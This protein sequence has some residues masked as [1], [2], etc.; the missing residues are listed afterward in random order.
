MTLTEPARRG[1]Q[2]VRRVQDVDLEAMTC[3]CPVHGAGARLRIRPRK[4]GESYI[5]RTCDRG[6]GPKS[7]G[8]RGAPRRPDQRREA[9]LLKTYGITIEEYEIRLDAQQGRCLI[10][11]DELVRPFI[12]HCHK[13]G[14]V[15]GI[16]CQHC[17][18]GLGFFKD[19]PATLERAIK[20]LRQYRTDAA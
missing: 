10:C 6:T 5:C 16:L 11:R 14:H 4:S 7:A 20:Y 15:R 17:N 9:H 13:L 18:S 12:D 2:Y 1:G 3:T 19:N 8:T